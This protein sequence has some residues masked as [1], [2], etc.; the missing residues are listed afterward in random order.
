MENTGK[1]LFTKRITQWE[2]VADFERFACEI[3]FE[4][5]T[6]SGE[7]KNYSWQII[8]YATPFPATSAVTGEFTPRWSVCIRVSGTHRFLQAHYV[9]AETLRM[10]LIKSRNW[11]DDYVNELLKDAQIKIP[12]K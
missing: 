7:T 9:D 8:F 12:I 1:V 10:A 11:G 2:P 3:Q 5:P 4:V 6:D